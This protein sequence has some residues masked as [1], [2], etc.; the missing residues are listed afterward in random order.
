[1][2]EGRCW[3]ALEAQGDTPFIEDVVKLIF[4]VCLSGA[5]A[6]MNAPLIPTNDPNWSRMMR[7]RV[8]MKALDNAED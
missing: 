7:H 2:R 3:A 8:V 5:S 6:D 1:M 4:A